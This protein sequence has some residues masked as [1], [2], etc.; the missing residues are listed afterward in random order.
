MSMRG[1][2]NAEVLMRR[3]EESE[4]ALLLPFYE[5]AQ[6]K[7]ATDCKQ[8]QGAAAR[9]ELS[10]RSLSKFEIDFIMYPNRR[11]TFAD[12]GTVVA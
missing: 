2:I 10:L 7:P 6:V 1:C 3:V 9:F 8:E 11:Y 4:C 12:P 5:S